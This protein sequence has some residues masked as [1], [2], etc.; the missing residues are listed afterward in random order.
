MC[1]CLSLSYFIMFK[2]ILNIITIFS[3]MCLS[4]ALLGFHKCPEGHMCI[5]KRGGAKL[6]RLE[7]PGWHWHEPALTSVHPIQ[8]TWQTDTLSPLSQ[9]VI[10]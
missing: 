7:G 1:L 6:D 10:G 9:R 8:T 3:L 2:N 4:E 5:Y